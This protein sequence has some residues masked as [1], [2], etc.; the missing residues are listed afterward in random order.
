MKSSI[1]KAAGVAS[2]LTLAAGGLTACSSDTTSG[3]SAGGDGKVTEVEVW[4][5]A[6]GY[7]EAAKIFNDTHDDIKIKYTQI[8]P[9]NKG[10]YDKIRNS[11]TAGNAPCLAQVGYE[12]L[13]SFVAEGNVMDVTEVASKDKDLYA[14]AG[15]AGVNVGGKTYGAPQDQGPMVLFYNKAVFEANGVAVPTTWDEYQAAGEKLKAAGIKL[16]G[17]Y[18]DYDYSGFAWQAGATWY[19]VE[20]SAWSITPDS[21][22]NLEVATYWQGL[23][24]ADMI[25]AGIWSDEWSAGLG[26][27]SIATIVGAAWFAGILKDSAAASSGDWAVAE[28]PQWTAG[29]AKTGNVGGS[30]SA[31]SEE[32]RVGKECAGLCRSRWSPYH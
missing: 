21:P 12:T 19:T 10:G 30:L 32:R 27:G 11:I 2:I 26:D 4:T 28:L 23:I 3:G 22:A 15:W 25:G 24:D 13:P 16:T 29:D 6:A 1:V 9:G 5:W 7:D 17:T 8:E 18:E 20:K 31:R 14:P